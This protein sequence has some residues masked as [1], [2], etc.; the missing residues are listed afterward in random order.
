MLFRLQMVESKGQKAALK[1]SKA[2]FNQLQEQ[3][4]MAGFKKNLKRPVE[5]SSTPK[6]AKKFKL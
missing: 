5:E 3:K 1:S 2:F 4:Q 6:T